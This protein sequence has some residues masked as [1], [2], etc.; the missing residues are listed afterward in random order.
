MPI[1]ESLTVELIEKEIFTAEIIEKAIIEVNL[2]SVDVGLGIRRNLSELDDVILTSP[3]DDEILSFDSASGLWINKNLSEIQLTQ[4]VMNET[5]VLISGTT[6]SVANTYVDVSIQIYVNGMKQI[7]TDVSKDGNNS[8]FTL[9][10]ILE[11]TDT[12]ECAYIKQD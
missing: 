11:P 8:R 6:Y 1:T 9:A 2:S 5:P 7:S 4:L 3:A 12:I 10:F